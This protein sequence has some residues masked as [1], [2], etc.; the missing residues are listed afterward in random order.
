MKKSIMTFASA[1]L[2]MGTGSVF[3]DAHEE[4]MELPNIVPVETFTCN[5]KDGQ[6]MADLN[7][8]TAAWNKWM[9]A[10]NIGYYYAATVTPNYFGEVMFDVGWLGAWKDGNAMGS[11]TDLW[12]NNGG[13]VNDQ[14]N[15]VCNWE[16]HTGYASMNIRP[17]G[18]DEEDDKTFVLSFSNCSAKEGKSFEDVMAGMNAWKEHQDANGFQASTWMMFPIYGESDSDYNFKLLEG[19][20]NHTAF[21]ADFELMGNGGH[22]VKNAEIFD[23]LLECDIARVYDAMTVRDWAEDD[24]G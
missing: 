5:F 8:A 9:D 18:D 7:K 16:S 10:Q 22:W 14:F 21:G 4:P 20:D 23:D 6:T 13:E 15:E 11:G 24:D 19:H 2:C 3:A 12:I 1:L 17:P